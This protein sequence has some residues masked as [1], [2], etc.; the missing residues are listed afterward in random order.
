[1]EKTAS[2][3]EEEV[4]DDWFLQED[5]DLEYQ[6]SLDGDDVQDETANSHVETPLQHD[7]QGIF[8]DP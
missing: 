2:K 5:S 6:E 3:V 8:W 4:V 7:D 1:M